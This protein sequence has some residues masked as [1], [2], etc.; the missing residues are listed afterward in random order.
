MTLS[1]TDRQKLV[2]DGQGMVYS[3][4]SQIY[5]NIPIRV[6]F[7]DLVAYGEVGLSQAARDFNP[8]TGTQFSTF[9]W[10]RIRGAIYDGISKMSWTSRARLRRARFRQ[11]ANEVLADDARTECSFS[12]VEEG[13]EWFRDVTGKL[14]VVYLATQTDSGGKEI[15]DDA[16]TA[17]TVVAR[18]EMF[19]QLHG[20]IEA[21]PEQAKRL[22]Q[23]IYYDGATL[24]QAAGRLGISKSWASR[25]HA[26]ILEQ[27]ARSLRSLDAE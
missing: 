9:A 24:Q 5:R 25:I 20:L 23:L 18:Q 26:K 2:E 17:S 4:A 14:T 8:E 21:L 22:I 15:E 11:M 7:E 6:D 16:E 13:A 19:D 27:L 3:L 10:F 1:Q 12:S